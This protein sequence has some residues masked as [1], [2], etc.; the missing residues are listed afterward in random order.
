MTGKTVAYVELSKESKLRE[1]L[2][3]CIIFEYPTLYI[4]VINEWINI[5]KSY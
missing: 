5:F 2:E 4:V 1:A 3:G